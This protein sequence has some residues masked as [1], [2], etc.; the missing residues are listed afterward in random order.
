MLP[1]SWSLGIT[2]KCMPGCMHLQEI[3]SAAA[4]GTMGGGTPEAAAPDSETPASPA[5]GSW[6]AD[7]K[8]TVVE[9]DVP[10]SGSRSHSSSNKAIDVPSTHTEQGGMPLGP[11]CSSPD[12]AS[13]AR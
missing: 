13:M 8:D 6:P 4:T 9:D 5:T 12:A 10:A 2:R 3:A 7:S 11:H 1:V